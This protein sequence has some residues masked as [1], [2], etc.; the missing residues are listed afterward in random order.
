[1]SLH[2]RKLSSC[3]LKCM[4]MQP[5]LRNPLVTLH[6]S[7]DVREQRE[8]RGNSFSCW[9]P[10][11]QTVVSVGPRR[12]RQRGTTLLLVE[13]RQDFGPEPTE[14]WGGKGGGGV[15]LVQHSTLESRSQ[16]FLQIFF[17]PWPRK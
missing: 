10:D 15:F 17:Q 12:G 11:R 2:A 3:Q 4:W 8:V 1:S 14:G 7:V 13:R 9:R 5:C 6:P 16:K